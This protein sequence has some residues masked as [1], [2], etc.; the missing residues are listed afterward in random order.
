MRIC[1]PSRNRITLVRLQPP[2][3][4]SNT[5]ET[6]LQVSLPRHRSERPQA[7]QLLNPTLTRL[8]RIA[9]L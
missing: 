8:L 2:L 9:P 5:A 4:A 6:S 7:P 1:L 3:F